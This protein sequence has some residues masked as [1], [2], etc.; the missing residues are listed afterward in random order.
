MRRKLTII[1]GLVAVILMGLAG[2]L[3]T[4]DK[5]RDALERTYFGPADSYREVAGIR[6]HVRDTGPRDAP[7][8]ILLH[9][10]GSSLLT[11][12]P[13][14][15]LMSAQYRVVRFDLPGFGLT[16]PDPSGD[17]SDARSMAV[18][19]GLMN[20]LGI[21]QASLIGNSMGGRIAWT[22]AARHADRVEKLVLVSPD[23]FA[24]GGFEYGKAPD[25]PLMLRFLPYV[26]P[27]PLLRASLKPAYGDPAALT[28]ALLRRYRDMLLAPGVRGAI[29]A[30]TAQTVLEDPVP[31][32]RR[33]KAPTLLLWGVQDRMIPVSNAADYLAA[34]PDARLVELPGLGHVPFEEAPERSLAPVLAF[35][36][37]AGR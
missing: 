24:S 7:A 27:T 1:L 32:L 10:F 9:G 12:E 34:L 30:R 22:F 2:W 8:I 25:V 18:L 35:L 26:L 14:A 37:L 31:L 16:G 17:Y 21:G 33:I 28:N 20:T 19:G 13:W 3:Y 4:P 6:L 15:E 29:L 11:W 36:G 23:G 5:T